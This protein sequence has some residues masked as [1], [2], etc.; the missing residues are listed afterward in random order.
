MPKDRQTF[1]N[2]YATRAITNGMAPGEAWA[3]AANMAD[4]AINLGHIAAEDDEIKTAGFRAGAFLPEGTSPTPRSM[5]D[6][7]MEAARSALEHWDETPPSP[8]VPPAPAAPTASPEIDAL[9]E[10]AAVGAFNTDAAQ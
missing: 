8:D 5:E 1:I 4:R 9:A 3:Q 10:E 7:R 6:M 2:D